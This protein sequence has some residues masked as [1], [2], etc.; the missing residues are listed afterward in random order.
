MARKVD[1]NAKPTPPPAAEPDISDLAIIHPDMTLPIAGRSVTVREYRFTNGMRARA[2]GAPLIAD[3]ER[4]V[5]SPEV[6]EATTEDYLDLLATHAD[7]VRELMLDS[8]E[9]IDAD[10]MDS[11]D[12]AD[13]TEL[14]LAWWG[15]CGRFFIRRVLA[16]MREQIAK[17]F[18]QAASAG[19]TSSD[20]SSTPATAPSTV[21]AP[22]TPSVN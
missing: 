3:L 6:A 7:L 9:G 1:P 2:K 20:A 12:D 5:A 21:C 16:K 22:S 13:G 4:L 15:V 17:Q 8:V 18:L 10:W 14:L 19:A 11:L